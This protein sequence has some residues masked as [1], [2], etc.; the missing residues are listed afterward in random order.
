[1]LMWMLGHISTVMR[2]SVGDAFMSYE[3]MFI[4]LVQGNICRRFI[5]DAD[6]FILDAGS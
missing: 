3:Q 6:S 1:V 2:C 5:L 4:T